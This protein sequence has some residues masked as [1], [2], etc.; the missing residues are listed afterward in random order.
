MSAHPGAIQR[1]RC[2]RSP[3]SWRIHEPGGSS[4]PASGHDA[5]NSI[6]R[7]AWRC[8]ASP[9][10]PTSPDAVAAAAWWLDHLSSLT[11]PGEIL[12]VV[13][14]I[15][16]IPNSASSSPASPRSST[17]GPPA[18]V[19]AEPRT[20]RPVGHLRPRRTGPGTG[21]R[22]TTDCRRRKHAMARVGNPLPRPAEKPRRRRRRPVSSCSSAV[23]SRCSRTFTL[24]PSSTASSSSKGA[25]ACA[26][27]SNDQPSRR[28]HL[29]RAPR[30]RDH[31][32]PRRAWP[33]AI[34]R[35]RL[36]GAGR[37]RHGAV[38]PHRRRRQSLDR[39]WNP[40]RAVES[41]WAQGS[42]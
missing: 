37:R 33:L 6:G 41:G 5:W 34:H 13:A 7:G 16:P 24:A 15:P 28:P 35:I 30:S 9:C 17:W 14:A 32:V 8:R 18:D 39:C 23:S 29:R 38:V 27:R 31:L 22:P 26:W 20:G 11:E 40:G 1:R 10:D 36:H 4:R 42:R 21:H 2:W 19:L 12:D 25:A 3:P